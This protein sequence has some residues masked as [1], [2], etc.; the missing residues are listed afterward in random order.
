MDNVVQLRQPRSRDT[1]KAL[2]I[3][4]EMARSDRLHGMI[5]TCTHDRGSGVIVTGEFEHPQLA[6][7]ELERTRIV[8]A[9]MDHESAQHRG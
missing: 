2:E 8:I 6:L 3:L 9:D 5:L 1:V 7:D 4:L